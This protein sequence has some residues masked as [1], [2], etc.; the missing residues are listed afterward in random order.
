MPFDTTSLN[1]IFR[2]IYGDHIEQLFT[3]NNPIFSIDRNTETNGAF[4]TAATLT[5]EMMQESMNRAMGLT[6]IV[7]GKDRIDSSPLTPQKY[8]AIKFD[9]EYI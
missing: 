1:G 6:D 5:I 4:T 2:E 9:E 3:N 7:I 8:E